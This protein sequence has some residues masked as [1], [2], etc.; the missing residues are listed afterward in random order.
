MPLFRLRWRVEHWK[1]AKSAHLLGIALLIANSL[2]AISLGRLRMSASDCLSEYMRLGGQ[3]FGN[4]QFWN[5]MRFGFL[6]LSTQP[7]Y[8]A[9]HFDAAVKSVCDRHNEVP[10]EFSDGV[11]PP[12][13]PFRHDL[14]KT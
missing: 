13:F 1:V 9:A 7:K 5:Q 6:H 8:K 12:R 14:C 2:I 10:K 3:V 4:P 11:E